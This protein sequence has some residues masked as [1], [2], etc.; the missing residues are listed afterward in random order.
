MCC[1]SGPV[2]FVGGTKIFARGLPDGRQT[3]AYAMNVQLD[4]ELAMILPLPVAP[5]PTEDA[6]SF[7]DL[8]GEAELFEQ[9]GAA[10]PP[11]TF[12]AARLDLSQSNAPKPR[13]AVLEVGQY[14]AS[15]VPTAAEFARLDARF[16]LPPGFI[17]ALPA[18]ADYGFAVFR[19]KP[20]RGLLGSKRQSVHPMALSF[21]R[22]DPQAL[23]FPTV[24]V[25]DGK[26]APKATF[27]HALYCQADGVLGATLGWTRATAPLGQHVRG[28][29]SRELIDVA[30]G[31]FA[32]SLWG[33]LSNADVWL[34][35]PAGVA[36][37]DLSG[38]GE[39]YTFEAKATWAYVTDAAQ[40]ERAAW[41]RSAQQLGNLCRQ[42]R[43]G[44]AQL[45]QTRRAAWRLGPLSDAL[46]PHFMNGSQ[47][48]CGTSYMNGAPA[49]S[50]GPARIAFT[51][52][53]ERVEPQQV[54]L[55]FSELP[56]QAEAV[57]IQ[58][59]LCRLVDRAVS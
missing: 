57:A 46:A 35:A 54:T 29:R 27:D 42:L 56:T 38:R 39:C 26:V 2:R 58:A 19:L 50:R 41:A 11:I 59:E 47:L 25:H 18:Y 43:G 23:F 13:L 20:Q 7:I 22:R 14:E 1:F 52:F 15:F 17:A 33:E 31:G 49:T 51:P 12:Q 40:T 3:L 10:F 36:P 53:S 37:S 21:P 45:E 5:S 24:H 55:G 9:L 16:R 30:A 32:Q 34:R 6:V 4:E 28:A 44:L 48:W 8:D